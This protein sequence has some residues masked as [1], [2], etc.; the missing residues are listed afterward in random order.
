MFFFRGTLIIRFADIAPGSSNYL[1][2]QSRGTMRS[3][4]SSPAILVP[5][6]AQPAP[7]PPQASVPIRGSLT[8]RNSFDERAS[9]RF[10][11]DWARRDAEFQRLL[12]AKGWKERQVRGDGACF[13]R[14]IS[15]LVSGSEDHHGD[16][17]GKAMDYIQSNEDMFAPFILEDFRGYV[18]R[19]R[20]P[21]EYANNVEIQAVSCLLARNVEVYRYSLEPIVIEPFLLDEAVIESGTGLPLRVTY[22]HE[23]VSLIFWVLLEARER[24]T[25]GFDFCAGSDSCHDSSTTTAF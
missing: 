9:Q 17:R 7:S 23:N 22:V 24:Q 1:D 16:I 11:Q 2:A 18:A 13:F 5:L 20:K 12:G 10:A 19:K 6:A 25:F 21:G 3:S 8:S 15:V 14:S 4:T